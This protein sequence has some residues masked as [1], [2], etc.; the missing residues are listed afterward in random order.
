MHSVY[1]TLR[2]FLYVA[3]FISLWKGFEFSRKFW[4]KHYSFQ[5][6]TNFLQKTEIN[7]KNKW[8]D[9]LQSTYSH[10]PLVLPPKS[11]Q[12]KDSQKIKQKAS[13]DTL[14]AEFLQKTFLAYPQNNLKT[15][16]AFFGALQNLENNAGEHYRI[17][18]F[19]DS[20]IEG[21][22]ITATLRTALQEKL[23]GCGVGLQGFT[24]TNNIKFSIQQENDEKLKNYF[25]LGKALPHKNQ[26]Y[27]ILGQ[28]YL[29]SE[30]DT[31]SYTIFRKSDKA[32]E[33]AQKVENIKILFRNTQTPTLIDIWEGENKLSQ[34]SFEPSSQSIY[35]SVPLQN[36]FSEIKITWQSAK[37]PEM[38]GVA[39]DCNRGITVDNIPLRG[40]AGLEFSKMN[41]TALQAQAEQLKPCLVILHFG[42]NVTMNSTDFGFYERKMLE[43][44]TFLKKAFPQA[45][46]VLVGI[47]DRSYRTENG[48]ET[49]PAVEILR[50]VQKRIAFQADCAFW[51]LYEAMGGK[52]TMPLWVEKGLASK[53]Y[54]HFTLKG[55]EII[56]NMLF[57][58]LW[59][60]FQ[61]Y[62]GVQ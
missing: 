59:N 31:A 4:D 43:Q 13:T 56:G 51:D 52:N 15:L 24:N 54:T 39:L 53:D 47:S 36:E 11:Y 28:T 14:Q 48:F 37:S 32:S 26:T 19:A 5:K 34:K 60:D 16:Q 57:E 49:Y 23:G 27:G 45:S 1:Q 17:F 58:A 22:R 8:I 29:Y 38:Y 30:K 12:A 9:S 55:A 50:R 35:W 33:K 42:V 10:S 40:S 62:K 2:I 25:L 41:L 7:S 61:S 21:D 18:Y 3:F 46:F 20:Q 6:E 44:I